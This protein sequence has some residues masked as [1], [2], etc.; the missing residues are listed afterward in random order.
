MAAASLIEPLV[1]ETGVAKN[2]IPRFKLA[3][4]AYP[5][6]MVITELPLRHAQPWSDSHQRLLGEIVAAIGLADRG[7][8]PSNYRE[9]HWPLDP[10]ASFDQSES[11]ARHALEVELDSMRQ[12]E[13]QALLLMGR[14]AAQYLL[15]VDSVPESGVLVEI[16]H[17][18]ALCCHGLNEVLRLPGLK[19]EL[20]RQ[21]QPLRSRSVKPT[22]NINSD[23]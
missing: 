17:L 18:P 4:V 20:W 23:C 11:V 9:F 3:L 12:P 19:A 22:A 13:Q 21:L 6:C 14:S 5:H 2:Q 16:N 1:G 8:H 10:A 15:P 7:Q